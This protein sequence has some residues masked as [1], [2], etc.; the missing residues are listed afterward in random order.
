MVSQGV[1]RRKIDK[2]FGPYPNE[3]SA[4][5]TAMD[6]LPRCVNSLRRAL[7]DYAQV[8]HDDNTSI[9]MIAIQQEGLLLIFIKQR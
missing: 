2:S 9:A 5:R 1:K 6:R 7:C 4:M 8:N 3:H